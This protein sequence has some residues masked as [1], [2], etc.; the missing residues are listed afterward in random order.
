MHLQHGRSGYPKTKVLK[1]DAAT[2]KLMWEAPRSLFGSS[3]VGSI[4]VLD[5]K[6]ILRGI[7]TEVLSKCKQLDPTC[8]L[9][10]ITDS[11]S[12][13]LVCNS[14]RDRDRLFKGLEVVL[15]DITTPLDIKY[16]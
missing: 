13:D 8:C 16:L 4:A 9:S 7:H 2:L 1:F 3:N 10:I 12:L 5:I 11:R 14:S 6:Q 15:Q